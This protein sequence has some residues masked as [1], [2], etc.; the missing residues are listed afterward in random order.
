MQRNP[1]TPAD[2]FHAISHQGSLRIFNFIATE[3]KKKINS[4]TL[5]ALNG[6][7]KKQYYLRM[8][9]L[10]KFGLV[11]RTLGVYQL[12]S[13]GKIV[14]SN[15]LKIDAAFENYWSL[16][17]VDS[18]EVTNKINSE[19]RKTLVKELVR[20]NVIQNILLCEI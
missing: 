13:F 15:K 5:Q 14:Y 20:D 10:T 12:T 6:L 19:S 17:A 4:Q 2:I 11:K 16:K 3:K 1:V 8:H 18:L 9:E 7:T